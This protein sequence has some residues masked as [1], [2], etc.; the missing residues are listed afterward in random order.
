MCSSG[1]VRTLAAMSTIARG[2]TAEAAVL[3]AL[4]AAGLTV[5][6]PFGGG[7]PYD[8]VADTGD[9]LVKVQ[10]KC[11][12]VRGDCIEFNSAGTNHGRG[13]VSYVGRADVFG[14]HAP[15][16]DRV[17]I[18]PVE[19]CAPNRGYLRLTPTRNN[20]RRRVRFAADYAVD[21]WAATF[22]RGGP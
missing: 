11:G 2:N 12:R 16:L 22:A 17:F 5:L 1:G 8:L 3:H 6:V 4:S 18:V 19:H 21:A 7:T 15:E 10:V 13:Q 9:A 20:Q 14:V